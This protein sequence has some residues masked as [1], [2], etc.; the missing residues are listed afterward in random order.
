MF[1]RRKFCA[2]KNPYGENSYSGKSYGKKSYDENP[3]AKIPSA[4]GKTG[5]AKFSGLFY[6][7]K[8]ISTPTFKIILARFEKKNY[9]NSCVRV[10]TRLL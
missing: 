7:N 1:V 9:K 2:V 4:T 6:L 3:K 8:K 10:G 5:S